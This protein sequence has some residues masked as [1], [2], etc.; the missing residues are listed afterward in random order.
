MNAMRTLQLLLLAS[1]FTGMSFS[2]ESHWPSVNVGMERQEALKK[3]KLSGCDVTEVGIQGSTDIAGILVPK[4]PKSDISGVVYFAG[5]KVVGIAR[6]VSGSAAP[7]VYENGM[8]LYRLLADITHGEQRV[9]AIRTTTV[10]A[11]NGTTRYIK[12]A[13]GEGKRVNVELS[14]PDPSSKRPQGVILSRCEG[15]CADW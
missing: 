4:E 7:E 3:I 2:Q 9:A 5:N 1:C 15:T 12:V 8:V 14:D 10:E 13:F 6:D 11:N